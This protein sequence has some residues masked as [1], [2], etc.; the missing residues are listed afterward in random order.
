MGLFMFV[1]SS[2]QKLEP[3]NSIFRDFPKKLCFFV[4]KKTYFEIRGKLWIFWTPY[5]PIWKQIL[6]T[7]FSV[8]LFFV[9]ELFFPS[10]ANCWKLKI[11]KSTSPS[12]QDTVNLLTS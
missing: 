12:E 1:S 8:F 10:I 3:K 2:V 5:Q 6:L 11:Q 9:L 7:L 4:P